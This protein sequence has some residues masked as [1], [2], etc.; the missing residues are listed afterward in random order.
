MRCASMTCVR[1]VA[2]LRMSLVDPT[3]DEAAVLDRERFGARL[4]RRRS[5]A[6]AR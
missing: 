1:R 4:P 3:A 5:S 6:H 2:R